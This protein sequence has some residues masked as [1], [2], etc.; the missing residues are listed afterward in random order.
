MAKTTTKQN[1]LTVED[2]W[3]IERLGPPSIAPDGAHAVCSLTRFSM[4]ENKSTASL[5]LLSTLGGAPRALTQC[6]EKDGQP[7][8]S[9]QGHLVGFVA[10]RE[11]QGMKDEEAQFYVIPP[12]GGEA[13]RVATVATGVEAFRWFPDGKRIAF[14][15]WVWPELKGEKAQARRH[16]AWTE[17]KETGY[18]TSE[19][20]HRYWDHLVPMGRVPHL[21]V[22]EL[23]TGR[24]RDLFEGTDYELA[25]SEPDANTFDISPDGRRIVFSWDP[26]P[27][28]RLENRFALA[29]IDV[30]NGS[31]T[32]VV[33]DPEWDCGAPR[34]N[35]AGNAIAFLASHQERRHTMPAQLAVWERGGTGWEVV[36]AE[37]DHALNAPLH[38]EDD[39]QALLFLAE[40]R[41]RQHLWRF[42]LPDRRAEVVAQGGWVQ[43]FDK[44]A[45]VLV[46]GADALTHPVRLHAHLPGEAPRR[47]APV[48]LVGEVKKAVTEVSAL[49]GLRQLTT[50]PYGL[51][52]LVRERRRRPRAR[53]R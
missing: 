38:W 15:S 50:F 37:W 49:P 21:H 43:G 12:D 17:R 9:P 3:K 45:G 52:R 32:P 51:L 28:K 13:R 33:Q 4:E 2:L 19:A 10:K 44:A 16:K 14:V 11:Q 7:R 35:P 6:G 53:G 1:L 39:G 40:Q 26:A 30:R 8:F 36:S 31:V 25:R 34:Y 47:I 41:G 20:L 5:W 48:D 42:D 29:E 24:V 27:Q 22:M 23:D 46:T 18:A